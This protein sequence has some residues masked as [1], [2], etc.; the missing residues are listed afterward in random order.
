MRN[1]LSFIFILC[2]S[3]WNH[4][5]AQT[6]FRFADTNA[7][8]LLQHTV[9]F[10]GTEGIWSDFNFESYEVNGD[11][12][13]G[14]LSYQLIEFTPDYYWSMNSPALVRRDSFDK[15]FIYDF[16][17]QAERLIYDFS[18]SVGDTVNYYPITNIV[19]DTFIY[20]VDFV[21][22]V[23]I[24]KLRKRIFM[25]MI[26]ENISFVD[27]M[28][29]IDGIGVLNSH[30]LSPLYLE[31]SSIPGEAFCLMSYSADSLYDF[32]E[33]CDTLTTIG[34][35]GISNQSVIVSV[36]PNPGRNF[37]NFSLES[38]QQSIESISIFD[39]N[40]KEVIQSNDTRIDIQTLSSGMYFYS[41]SLRNNQYAKGRFLKE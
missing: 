22:S 25:S 3:I 36:Y 12:F 4:L 28:I 15:V 11:T 35:K 8:W 18:V 29:I 5:S 1:C 17:L 27:S 34:I 20:K 40:G 26:Y 39:L 31:Y 16:D 7:T 13:L 6:D 21:D 33:N 9:Y 30:F 37:I 19:T 32:S 10:E 14:N 38:P 41:I 23:E 24:D 2:S